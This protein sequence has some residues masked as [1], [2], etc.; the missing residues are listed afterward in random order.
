VQTFE[1]NLTPQQQQ[2]LDLLGVPASAYA[3]N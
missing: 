1:A 2:I 3:T